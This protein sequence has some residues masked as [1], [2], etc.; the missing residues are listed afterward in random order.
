[1]PQSIY[2]TALNYDTG[3]KSSRGDKNTIIE[4]LKEKDI[5]NIN[6]KNLI[7]IGDRDNLIKY[8]QFY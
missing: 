5:N 2:L 8:R 7:S 1:M 6:N 3:N 4:A